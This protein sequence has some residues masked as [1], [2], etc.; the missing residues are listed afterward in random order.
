MFFTLYKG[1]DI[2]TIW[3][4]GV[5]EAPVLKDLIPAD[6]YTQFE[7]MKPMVTSGG[8]GKNVFAGPDVSADA[9]TTL[10]KAFDDVCS[11][12]RRDES[13]CAARHR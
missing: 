2:K 5:K 8:L 1:T 10:R 13:A 6:L 7:S 4:D 9:M 11:R 3:P 12:Y